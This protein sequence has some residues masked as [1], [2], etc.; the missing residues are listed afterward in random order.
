MQNWETGGMD[1]CQPTI[2]NQSLYQ[3]NNDNGFRIVNFAIQKI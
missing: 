1:I 2:R 3:D